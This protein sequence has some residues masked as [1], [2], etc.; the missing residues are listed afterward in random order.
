[1]LVHTCF[2]V[3]A[4]AAAALTGW[5]VARQGWL[6]AKPRTP[7]SDP[8]YFIALGLG[9]IA[10]A[11]L[12]GSI[13]LGLAG[14]FV[15]GHS[16]A[17]A[18]AGG[19]IAVEIY[20]PIAGIKGSTGA[21]FVAPLAVG[22]AVGRLGCFFAG[23]PDYTYGTP[24]AL[25]W[26]V[27]FGDGVARHPVQLYESA[28]MLLFLIVYLGE[29][30]RGSALFRGRGFYLFVGWYACQRFAWE[31]LKPYPAIVGP[32]N[33]FHIVCVVLVAYSLFMLR[34]NHEF[35]AAVQGL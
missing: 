18:I 8:G 14:H 4:W 17:G 16:I 9:A 11:L 12:F 28:A 20:K 30:A 10:G 7:F 5:L 15:L 21:Q 24:T 34:R 33:V 2:D 22:I 26:G 32:F 29:I 3:L 35:R 25:P 27:D 1:M 31:F 23:L 19:V 13:N 6:G